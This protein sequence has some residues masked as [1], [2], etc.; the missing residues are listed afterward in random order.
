MNRPKI[1]LITRN[2]PPLVGGMERLNWHMADE[3]SKRAEVSVIGPKGSGE[4]KPEHVELTE[5]PLKPLP[6]FL[7]I[8]LLKGLWLALRNKPDVILAGSGLTAP[9][10]WLLSKLCGAKSA[11]YLHGFRSEEHT[12]ELQS[13]PH[14]VCRL[15][16]EKK[17]T[18]RSR[19]SPFRSRRVQIRRARIREFP[20]QIGRAHI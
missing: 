16:L 12:S 19:R 5:A 1:L 8:A 7:I 6:L 11:V 14:L 10:V 3:L 15:L 13:R 9:I 2:L 17:N 20:P 4:L 18:Q